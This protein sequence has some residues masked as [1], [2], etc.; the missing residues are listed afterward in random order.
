MVI[1]TTSTPAAALMDANQATGHQNALQ[2]SSY[3]AIAYRR[4]AAK[5]SSKCFASA[6]K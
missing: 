4:A 2:V 6:I 3:F 5:M 1:N